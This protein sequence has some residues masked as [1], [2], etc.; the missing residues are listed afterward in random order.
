M[1]QVWP[2]VTRGWVGGGK[3]GRCQVK[4]RGHQSPPDG[5]DHST[6]PKGHHS[7]FQ[8]GYTHLARST[9]AVMVLQGCKSTPQKSRPIESGHGRHVVQ[10]A[11]VVYSLILIP[12]FKHAY[13][14]LTNR[15]Q[16][17][18]VEGETSNSLKVL[19]GVPQGTVLGPLMFLLYINDISAGINLSIRLFTDDCVL[20]RVI[21]S[22]EDHEHLQQ[23]LNTLV[24]W[25]EQWQMILNPAK[26]VTLNCTRSLLP[27][28]AAYFINNTPLN[29]VEQHKYLGVMMNKSMSWSGHIQEIINKASK[30]LNLVKR[31]LP[32]AHHLSKKLL[33]LH[34]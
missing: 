4:T 10:V 21:K 11:N 25:T 26:C 14:W 34:W 28:V 23:D 27:S 7:G 1:Q 9:G 13:V 20:Y 5:P 32:S 30:T 2:R 24:K 31:I 19:S 6:R 3:E 22:T 17:V 18:V 8:A 29:S 16:K 12:G 33:I 15:T